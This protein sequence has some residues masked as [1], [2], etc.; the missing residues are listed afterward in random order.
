M[1]R[2][3]RSL[4]GRFRQAIRERAEDSRREA[5]AAQRARERAERARAE[6]FQDLVGFAE[7]TGFL[8]AGLRDGSLS[9]RFGDRELRFAPAGDGGEVVLDWDGRDP[10]ETHRL[11]VEQRLGEDTWVWARK[12]RMRL[13]EE[14]TLFWD[15]GLEELLVVALGLPRPRGDDGGGDRERAL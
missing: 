4:A 15:A 6:L 11:Y 9:L 13:R 3:G 7:D 2:R 5:D 1:G 10:E 12:R 14:R 8:Q